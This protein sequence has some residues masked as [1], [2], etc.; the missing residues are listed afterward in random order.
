MKGKFTDEEM[1]LFNA[2]EAKKEPIQKQLDALKS[3]VR[4]RQKQVDVVRAKIKA[5]KPSLVPHAEMQA[6]LANPIS[7]DKYFPDMSKNQF[8]AHVKATL[9]K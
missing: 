7:R 5:I 2:L 6:A 8:I 9:N 1:A 3:Q 4:E